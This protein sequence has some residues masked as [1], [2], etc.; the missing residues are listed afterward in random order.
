MVTRNLRLILRFLIFLGAIQTEQAFSKPECYV[1]DASP[2]AKV[3]VRD[4][5]TGM[6]LPDGNLHGTCRLLVDQL[7]WREDNGRCDVDWDAAWKAASAIF[8]TQQWYNHGI[9]TTR[10]C[11]G[12]FKFARPQTPKP[13]KQLT[14]EQLNAAVAEY[15]QATG[16]SRDA[17]K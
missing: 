2:F 12:Y 8:A 15:L 14:P 9:E 10:D 13:Q 6:Q 4:P 5:E 3:R 1:V 16:K 17:A 7:K 11:Y